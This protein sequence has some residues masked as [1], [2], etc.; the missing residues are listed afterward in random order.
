LDIFGKLTASKTSH[1]AVLYHPKA[2]SFWHVTS[3]MQSFDST[4][5]NA[6]QLKSLDFGI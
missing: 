6:V 3:Q 1:P 4:P 2:V 5:V